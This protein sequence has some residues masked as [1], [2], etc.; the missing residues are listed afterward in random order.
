MKADL[1]R[2]FKNDI[3]EL[4]EKMKKLES[5]NRDLESRVEDRQTYYGE[6]L[7][8]ESQK[9]PGRYDKSE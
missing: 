7:K 1:E 9:L 8:K 3:K 2:T 5:L 6:K 4:H